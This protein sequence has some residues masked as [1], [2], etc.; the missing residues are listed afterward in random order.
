MT[1]YELLGED[2]RLREVGYYD[3]VLGEPDADGRRRPDEDGRRRPG[4]VTDCPRLAPAD[5]AI[6]AIGQDPNPTLDTSAYDLDRSGRI[7]VDDDTLETNVASVYAGGDAVA[8]TG[9][10]VIF[11]A[12][13]GLRAARA[14]HARLSG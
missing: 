4:A 3:N 9:G 14:I 12:G 11:A 13:C 6:I 2:G 7:I 8:G 10:T 1:P 5:I